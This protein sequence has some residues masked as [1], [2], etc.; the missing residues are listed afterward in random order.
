MNSHDKGYAAL[1]LLATLTAIVCAVLSLLALTTAYQSVQLAEKQAALADSQFD[2]Q[3]QAYQWL[4]K[5]DSGLKDGSWDS[6]ETSRQFD[7][8]Q[9]HVLMVEIVITDDEYKIV[10][11][12]SVT[13]WQD[14]STIPVLPAGS[15]QEE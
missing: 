5:V 12:Q 8:G 3:K 11:W 13:L 2:C 1:C 9:N 10:R 7:D 14:D 15:Q 4:E 6:S